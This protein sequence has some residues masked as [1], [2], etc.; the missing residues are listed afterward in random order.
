MRIVSLGNFFLDALDC[1]PKGDEHG[2]HDVCLVDITRLN[3]ALAEVVSVSAEVVG[4]DVGLHVSG[5][6]FVFFDL[7]RRKFGCS[8][9]SSMVVHCGVLISVPSVMCR[10]LS[11]GAYLCRSNP[12]T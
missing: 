7:K 1:V 2:R 8:I 10:Q 12:C 3:L 11:S 6:Y 5:G 9:A 4:H